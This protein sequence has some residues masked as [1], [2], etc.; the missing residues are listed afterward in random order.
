MDDSPRVD[1]SLRSA[2]IEKTLPVARAIQ[3]SPAAPALDA[4]PKCKSTN[5]L[6]EKRQGGATICGGCQHV[7]VPFRSAAPTGLSAKELLEGT[8]AD[9]SKV[10]SEEVAEVNAVR[11]VVMKQD[12]DL[13]IMRG[14]L[15][16]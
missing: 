16:A 15:N 5:L 10:Q 11:E 7:L 2:I 4:C 6:V 14:I 9:R 3:T 12:V 8:L 13:G 1:D